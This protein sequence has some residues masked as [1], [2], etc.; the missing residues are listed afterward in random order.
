MGSDEWVPTFP[1]F[2]PQDSGA[3]GAEIQRALREL[4]DLHAAELVASQQTTN[5]VV[6][7]SLPVGSPTR[8]NLVSSKPPPPMTNTSHIRG[9]PTA[10][11]VPVTIITRLPPLNPDSITVQV[12]PGKGME[13]PN[14]KSHLKRDIQESEESSSVPPVVPSK[15]ETPQPRHV[16]PPPGSAFLPKYTPAAAPLES[17]LESLAPL[18]S[19]PLPEDQYELTE[20]EES[21]EPE[22]TEEEK[23]EKR[24]NKNIPSWCVNWIETAKTQTSIDPET[25]FG[26]QLPKCDLEVLFGELAKDSAYLRARKGKRG[27]SGEWS[28]DRITRNELDEYRYVMGHTQQLE[29]VVI[30][31]V[32]N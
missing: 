6:I 3:A 4:G 25:I 21:D 7:S 29:S 9:S 13:T 1:G 15:Y 23:E 26:T 28:L 31:S 8:P 20:F 2:G 27:S 14:Q 16:F 11:V 22:L 18:P 17:F 12:L 30:R 19:S 24:M 10:T 32:T 5:P